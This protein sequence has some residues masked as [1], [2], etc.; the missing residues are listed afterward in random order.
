[1]TR[2]LKY[3]LMRAYL[4][5]EGLFPLSNLEISQR[6]ELAQRAADLIGETYSEHLSQVVLFGSLAREK[7]RRLGT[8]LGLSG[9][10]KWSGSDID[11]C[12]AVSPDMPCRER[13][14]LGESIGQTLA[15]ANFE[16]GNEGRQI[17]NFVSSSDSPFF[18]KHVRPGGK[19]LWPKGEE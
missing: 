17:H 19:V 3:I 1:L 12:C 13:E 2:L 11:F 6:I 8:I 18:N 14:N 16:V 15:E 7:G 5:I 4:N 10:M 9:T